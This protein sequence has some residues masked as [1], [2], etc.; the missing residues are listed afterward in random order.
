MRKSVLFVF[1]F[2]IL[3]CSPKPSQEQFPIF[4]WYGPE[5]HFADEDGYRTLHNAG[6][7]HSFS[8]FNK[9]EQNLQALDAAQ[10]NNVKLIVADQRLSKVK[11]KTDSTFFLIDSIIADYGKH[12]A[13]WGYYLQDE[14][15]KDDFSRLGKIS[16]YF[17]EKDSVHSTYVNLFPTYATPAQLDTAD[18]EG[19]V[20]AFIDSTNATYLSYDHYP[21][22]E[23]GL[24]KDYYQN[25]EIV[26]K[27]TLEYDIPFWAFSLS[28]HHSPYA[29]P[30]KSHLQMQVYSA[31]G[32]GA[33]AIQYFTYAKPKSRIWRFREAIVDVSGAPTSIYPLVQTINSEIQHLSSTLL[34]LKST[35]VYHSDPVPLDCSAVIPGL[36]ITKIEGDNVLAG[37]FTGPANNKYVMLVNKN[38]KSGV[39]GTFYFKEKIKQITEIQKNN[40]KPS[41]FTWFDFSAEKS[42]QILFKAGEGKL[43]Q[44]YD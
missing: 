4:A 6:F 11:V 39:L 43:F 13:L 12:P 33:K 38:Y 44:I 36:P 35:G 37:F 27:T 30:I 17:A 40:A 18:Y 3:S 42:C 28:V 41:E 29:R 25:F 5:A 22:R 10:K 9:K 8:T 24:R 20:R 7:T 32:Y 26:R 31:L 16:R 34:N 19:Y 2:L 21:I 14:P 1:A 15:G 23:S